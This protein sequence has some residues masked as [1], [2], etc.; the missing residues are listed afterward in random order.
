MT[1]GDELI[2]FG[3]SLLLWTAI[4]VLAYL[5]LFHWLRTAVGRTR[6]DAD[7]VVLSTIR[8]PLIIAIVAYGLVQALDQLTLVASVTQFIRNAYVVTLIAAGAYLGWRII[9]EV[10]LRWLVRRSTET[11]SRVDDLIVPLIST[12][13]PLIFFLIAVTSILQYLGIDVGLLAASLGI[14]GLVVGLAFQDSLANLFS[15]IYLMIDPAFLEN[16]LIE[17]GGKV[18]SVEKVGLRMTRMYDMVT[19]SLIFV[20]NKELTGSK[21]TNITRPTIDLKVTM[22]VTIPATTDPV[23]AITVLHDVVASHRNVLG[24]TEVKLASLRKRID[25]LVNVD[26]KIATGERAATLSAAFTA[27]ETWLMGDA[28]TDDDHA[29]VIEVRKEMNDRLNEAQTA[30]RRLPRGR[31]GGDDLKRLHDALGGAENVIQEIS[32]NRIERLNNALAAVRQRYSAAEIEPLVG[33]VGRLNELD[34]VEDE[35]ENSIKRLEK[36][37]E[38]ELDRLMSALVW[39]GDWLAEEMIQAGH[40]DEAAR[41]SLWV[42]TMASLYS[43]VEVQ[44]SVDGTDKELDRIAQWLREM[45]LG[46]LTSAERAR[47]RTLFGAWGGLKQLEVRRI[48]EL[49][50]RIKRWMDWKE[51]DTISDTEF[52][53]IMLIWDRKLR[54]LSKKIPDT[55]VNDE[56]TLDTQLAATRKWLHSVNFMETIPEWKLPSITVKSF[57]GSSMLYNINFNVDDIKQQHFERS[58]YVMSGIL[59]DLYETCKREGIEGVTA[60]ET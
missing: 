43:E 40:H 36:N 12:L 18:Y 54:V 45:E 47:I 2:A 44:E 27:L 53:N 55:G 16:D 48:A 3:I 42:R 20:P 52:E 24:I 31:L 1:L 59:L 29:R 5:I 30:L 58:A 56:E 4:A 51:K 50:R 26:Q 17:V 46:G 15:G 41:I 60:A 22:S 6:F 35:L 19:H 13:G 32:E 39:S 11:D 33:A 14:V 49:R 9:K 38:T 34:A 25:S 7:N 28:G 21:I 57:D 37:R 8:V 23:K 10:I